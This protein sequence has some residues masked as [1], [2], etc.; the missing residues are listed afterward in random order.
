MNIMG[1]DA[2]FTNASA[3]MVAGCLAAILFLSVGG[4]R[5][6]LIPSHW[7]SLAEST[8]GFVRGMVLD[9]CGKEGLKYFP[10]VFTLFTFVLFG[11]LL[12]ML[13]YSFTTTSQLI[14]TTALA[15]F[16]FLGAVLISIVKHGLFKFLKNF[17]PKDTPI[18]IAPLI[19]I[20]EVISF[21]SRPLS[22][23]L[24]LCANMIVGHMILKVAAGLI[25]L[26]ITAG[27][28]YPFAFGWIPY[29]FNTLFIGFEIAI[30]IL[31]AYIFTV[32]T[33][34]YLNDALHLHH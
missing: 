34:V 6:S 28:F 15:G 31:Q 16:V 10:I 25:V 22:L 18:W 4:R 13:P 33:C 20:I 14:T 12:G 3:W 29:A 27:S 23:S 21:L 24:R 1:W 9:N 32:L 19:Y 7:Q 8:V 26:T 2:T 30:A 5:L 11:N 17:L